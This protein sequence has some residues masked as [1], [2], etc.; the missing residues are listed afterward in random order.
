MDY[1][2]SQF[3]T[4]KK[5]KKWKYC[6]VSKWQPNNRFL[7]RVISILAK[8]WKTT[9]P[10]EF[11]NEI[12]LKVGEHKYIYITEIIFKKI[13][14][15]W[16][17]GQNNFLILRNN[18]N[19]LARKRRGRFKIFFAPKEAYPIV[20]Q[21]EEITVKKAQAKVVKGCWLLKA[22]S[23]D[24]DLWVTLGNFTG[25]RKIWKENLCLR[26]P[27]WLIIF[28]YNLC[29]DDK[30]NKTFMSYNEPIQ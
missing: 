4:K 24:T 16:N 21:L 12:W 17:G 9:F 11:F 29:S 25:K 7:F 30:L 3:C 28:G 20:R 18:A 1:K 19:L 26:W 10:K 2:K 6:T 8:I 27:Y 14:S 23:W 15:F 5:K 13:I 22:F